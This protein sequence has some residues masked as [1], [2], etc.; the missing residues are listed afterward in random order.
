MTLIWKIPKQ[1]GSANKCHGPKKDGEN[2][3]GLVCG[4]IPEMVWAIEK[5]R[6]LLKVE[7]KE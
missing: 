7:Y 1:V 2:E 5:S 4:V 6:H 3:G